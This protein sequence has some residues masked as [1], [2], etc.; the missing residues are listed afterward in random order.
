M[1]QY[2]CQFCALVVALSDC[3]GSLYLGG[4]LVITHNLLVLSHYLQYW[5]N[6]Q[7]FVR[8]SDGYCVKLV[9]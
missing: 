3:I 8:A 7:V 1:S 2:P 9:M 6:I 5:L 4:P